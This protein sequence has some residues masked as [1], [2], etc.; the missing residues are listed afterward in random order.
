MK[1]DEN[2]EWVTLNEKIVEMKCW[3]IFKEEI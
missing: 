3:K 2:G 1:K